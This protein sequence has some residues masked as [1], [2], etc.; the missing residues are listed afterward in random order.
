MNTKSSA[1]LLG[2]R[3]LWGVVVW[4]VLTILIL[5]GENWLN[6]VYLPQQSAALG[7]SQLPPSDASANALR[8]FEWLKG[9]VSSGTHV[10]IFILAWL[11]WGMTTFRLLI[12]PAETQKKQ[13]TLSVD[14]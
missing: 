11:F 3:L 6:Q 13:T 14:E 1:K 12:A 5:G 10:L 7:V 2:R 8:G 4:G 9:V